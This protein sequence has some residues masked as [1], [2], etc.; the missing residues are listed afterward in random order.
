MSTKIL[1]MSTA[2]AATVAFL[3]TPLA[4]AHGR[5]G[6]HFTTASVPHTHVVERHIQTHVKTHVTA[7]KYARVVKKRERWE[8]REKTGKQ[9]AHLENGGKTLHETRLSK[10][11]KRTIVA[12]STF[13]KGRLNVPQ[14]IKPK[15]TYLKSANPQFQK[16]MSPFV[17]KYWKKPYF[18]VALVDI[19]Y[20]TVPELYYDRF[21]GCLEVEDYDGCVSLLSTAAIEEEDDAVRVRY[22]MPRTASYRF[23]AEVENTAGDNG[24]V[25]PV[26]SP[27]CSFDRFIERKWNT[28]FV[29]VRIPE[30][31]NVTVPEDYYER[32]RESLA[33]SPPNYQA[34]CAVLV[35][36]AAADMMTLT[37][38]SNDTQFPE[39]N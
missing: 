3:G 19:G 21:L 39:L 11:P 2:L 8:K 28:A 32:F 35:E 12:G 18:W 29:W 34:G 15:L 16:K 33:G 37:G 36:A 24:A 10:L 20:V 7:K 5:G 30:T 9:L 14:N 4:E 23:S 31:G 25:R 22:P 38:A 27:T 17:Q 13:F 1:S 6:G 26:N